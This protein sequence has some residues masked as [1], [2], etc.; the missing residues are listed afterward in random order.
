MRL[1]PGAGVILGEDLDIPCRPD[2][3][4]ALD[5]RVRVVIAVR[6]QGGIG[7]AAHREAAALLDDGLRISR[8][9]GIELHVSG[10]KDRSAA[11]YI[12]LRI[13]SASGAVADIGDRMGAGAADQAARAARRRR[14]DRPGIV[15]RLHIQIAALDD[16][17]RAVHIGLRGIRRVA[18]R[19]EVAKRRQLQRAAV[20]RERL[21]QILGQCEQG[22]LVRRQRQRFFAARRLRAVSIDEHAVPAG[23]PRIGIVDAGGNGADRSRGTLDRRLRAVA[24]LAALDLI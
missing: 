14:G 8:I 22:H 2:L 24:L 21:R 19:I 20:L 13:L 6:R 11:A 15:A 16:D 7:H 12:H 3:T 9:V 1:G 18:L 5:A 17:V 23:A 4:G 10:C